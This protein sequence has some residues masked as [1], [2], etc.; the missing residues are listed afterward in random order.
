[1]LGF[2]TGCS[3][4]LAQATVWWSTVSH[5]PLCASHSRRLRRL[6][7]FAARCFAADCFA[8]LSADLTCAYWEYFGSGCITLSFLEGVLSFVT[9]RLKICLGY[10]VVNTCESRLNK[11]MNSRSLILNSGL[12]TYG[13]TVQA[14]DTHSS[15]SPLLTLAASWCTCQPNEN[16]KKRLLN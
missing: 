12:Q 2:S 10:V 1:M 4:L 13:Y 16:P 6:G 5:S 14:S 8:A 11:S 7:C 3:P 15:Y 9:R